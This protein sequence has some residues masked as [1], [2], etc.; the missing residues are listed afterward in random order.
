MPEHEFTILPTTQHLYRTALGP[1]FKMLGD[2]TAPHGKGCDAVLAALKEAVQAVQRRA[3]EQA[4]CDNETGYVV[5]LDQGERLVDAVE[6]ALSYGR[7]EQ[8]AVWDWVRHLEDT[9]EPWAL[10]TVTQIKSQPVRNPRNRELGR[11]W[12]RLTLNQ[13]TLSASIGLLL[14]KGRQ[15]ADAFYERYSVVASQDRSHEL[16]R[17]LMPIGGAD[18]DLRRN[19]VP[20]VETFFTFR[21]NICHPDD[22]PLPELSFLSSDVQPVEVT[23]S[24][25]VRERRLSRKRTGSRTPQSLPGSSLTPRGLDPAPSSVGSASA[26]ASGAS[27]LNDASASDELS[28]RLHATA[29]RSTAPRGAQSDWSDNSVDLDERQ[30]VARQLQ[31]WRMQRAGGGAA[32][33]TPLIDDSPSPTETEDLPQVSEEDE[34]SAVSA[35]VSQKAAIITKNRTALSIE[36]LDAYAAYLRSLHE[37]TLTLLERGEALQSAA[38]KEMTSAKQIAEV[39]FDSIAQ[40]TCLVEVAEPGL[41]SPEEGGRFSI[42]HKQSGLRVTISPDGDSLMLSRLHIPSAFRLK[43]VDTNKGPTTLLVHSET[44]RCIVPGN[45][46]GWD[47][48]LQLIAEDRMGDRRVSWAIDGAGFL[49]E[50]ISGKCVHPAGGKA[51][52]GVQLVLHTSRDNVGGRLEWKLESLGAGSE[53]CGAAEDD[54]ADPVMTHAAVPTI[55]PSILLS[56]LPSEAFTATPPNQELQISNTSV[57]SAGRAPWDQS[58]VT[59][60]DRMKLILDVRDKHADYAEK[61]RRI[62]ARARKC[63]GCRRELKKTYSTP[64]FQYR[65]DTVR[66]CWYTGGYYC[67]GCHDNSTEIPIPARVVHNWDVVPRPVCRDAYLFLKNLADK[68]VVCVSAMNPGLFEKVS[69]LASARETRA[70]LN[71]LSEIV[72]KCPNFA[73]QLADN[74]A[75]LGSKGYTLNETELYSME[76]L[77]SFHKAQPTLGTEPVLACTALKELCDTRDVLVRHVTKSCP[78]YCNKEG[79]VCNGV[80]RDAF[81][82]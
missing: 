24:R 3:A 54:F 50:V 20:H 65:Y 78:S 59:Q 55:D 62:E 33:P 36:G 60:S 30:R 64:Y 6:C 41:L 75:L 80:K 11:R 22:D 26:S 37:H 17:I 67:S 73:T 48:C 40:G 66:F 16:L 10:D 5:P 32:V 29:A 52:D 71:M 68:P 31:A 63:K 39:T 61:D 12:I 8:V 76:D 38:E 42:C 7:R 34:V 25:R 57:G 15:V 82:E 56:G 74:P 70:Q 23:N 2:D 51:F 49:A 46:I 77:L 27:V 79:K 28:R 43:K 1:T 13:G 53:V 69:V 72:K 14:E 19:N 4:Q 35:A 45:F 44:G 9:A 81:F 47:P 18:L 58:D 21:Q